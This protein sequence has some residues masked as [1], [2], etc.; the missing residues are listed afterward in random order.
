MKIRLKDGV[1]TLD[2]NFLFCDRDRHGNRRIYFRRRHGAGLPATKI[3]LRETPGTPAFDLEYRR[4]FQ[5]SLTAAAPAMNAAGKPAV[6]TVSWLCQEYYATPAFLG[7]GTGTR[8]VRRRILDAICDRFGRLPYAL[9]ETKHVIKLR[10]EKAAF[11]EAANAR[12]KALRQLFRWAK[13]YGHATANPAREAGYLKGNNPD[14][15]KAWTEADV[16]QFEAHHPLGS[17]ARL[18]LDLALYTGA[19]RSD[20]VR[21]GPQMERDGALFF[22]EQKGSAR[23]TKSH[24]IPILAPLRRSLDATPTGHLVYMVNQYGAPYS[25]EGFGQ[26]FKLR[27]REAGVDPAV[28]LHGLRKLGAQRCAEAGASEHQIMALFGWTSTKQ[29]ALYTRKASRVKLEREA[30]AALLG[31]HRG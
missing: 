24:A 4:A 21:M 9:M 20:L 6:G 13:E 17:K 10:D 30:V 15:F 2:Y 29:A 16:R 12:I 27:C 11:P 23:I 26:W 14:G 8:K 18:A 1:G 28:S 31:V 3:R 5:A 25:V 19:R 22:S 7:L